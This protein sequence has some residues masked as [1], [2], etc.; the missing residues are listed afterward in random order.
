MSTSQHFACNWH[1]NSSLLTF[2][3]LPFK[4]SWLFLTAMSTDCSAYTVLSSAYTSTYTSTAFSFSPSTD[5]LI[6]FCTNI[7]TTTYILFYPYISTVISTFSFVLS[8]F[9]CCVHHSTDTYTLRTFTWADNTFTSLVVRG[10]A[11]VYVISHCEI[12]PIGINKLCV[13]YCPLGMHWMSM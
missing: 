3:F 12:P 5:S 2:N 4:F 1:F 11:S 7:L 9:T 8:V 6:P 13:N 10:A